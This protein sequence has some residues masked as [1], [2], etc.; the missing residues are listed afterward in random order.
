M[1]PPRG[2]SILL[3]LAL[4]LPSVPAVAQRIAFHDY[5]PRTAFSPDGKRALAIDYQQLKL[6]DV[7]TGEECLTWPAHEFEVYAVAFSPDGRRALSGDGN[8]LRLRDMQTGAEVIRVEGR[9]GNLSSLA[10]SPDGRFAV[11]GHSHGSGILLDPPQDLNL[12][13]L[14]RGKVVFQEKVIPHRWTAQKL[15]GLLY[16]LFPKTSKSAEGLPAQLRDLFE[17]P[18]REERRHF[19]APRWINSVAFSPQGHLVLCGSS[20]GTA[21]LLHTTTGREVNRWEVGRDAVSRG[22]RAPGDE[23]NLWLAARDGVWAVAFSPDAGHVLTG[24]EKGTVSLWPTHGRTEVRRLLGHQGPVL[25]LAFS[26]DGRQVLSA[27]A[28]KTVRLWDLE[29]A[30]E[31]VRLPGLPDTPSSV[32]FANDGRYALYGDEE[33]NVRRWRL[34]E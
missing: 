14:H 30:E 23:V 3:L 8:G 10:I 20:D 29:S 7:E 12:F 1:F 4:S 24:T 32:R 17:G 21:R 19:E 27:G 25:D 9:N 6:L 33:G 5:V 13:D 11:S 2:S 31:V 28:D 18:T 34:T 26:P 16:E 22:R 15:L